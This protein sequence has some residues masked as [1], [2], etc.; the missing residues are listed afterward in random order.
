MVLCLS[1]N[2]SEEQ[3]IKKEI[4]NCFQLYSMDISPNYAGTIMGLATGIAFL[5]GVLNSGILGY[6]IVGNVSES[7]KSVKTCILPPAVDK[8]FYN[9]GYPCSMAEHIFVYCN[10]L[11]G[12]SWLLWLFCRFRS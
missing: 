7:R 12:W 9:L 5:A 3:A 2:K 4:I 8:A 1:F 10:L 6:F 11:G